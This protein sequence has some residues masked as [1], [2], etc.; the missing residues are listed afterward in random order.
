MAST[1][2][3]SSGVFCGARPRS[4]RLLA[5]CVLWALTS[6]ELM[7]R[8][9]RIDRAAG[10]RERLVVP[11]QFGHDREQDDGAS[12]DRRPASPASKISTSSATLNVAAL[13]T[14]S[15]SCSGVYHT[16]SVSSSRQGGLGICP[17]PQGA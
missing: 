16:D 9:A 13:L 8:G 11:D 7:P 17:A 3:G 6:S 12:P 14:R 5:I 10:R 15:S 2:S 1:C 4:R